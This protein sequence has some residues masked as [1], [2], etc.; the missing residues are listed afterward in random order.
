M[1]LRENTRPCLFGL[2]SECR[3]I[4]LAKKALE[5]EGIEYGNKE[6]VKIYCGM[7]VKA[8]YAKAHLE[9]AQSIKVVNTL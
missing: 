8:M 5:K 2:Y 4:K 7:C 1:K 9:R 6:F 3:V